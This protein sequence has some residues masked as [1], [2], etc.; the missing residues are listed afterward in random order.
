MP[1]EDSRLDES[2][3]CRG[4]NETLPA[5]DSLR[6]EARFTLY[7]R[8]G[9]VWLHDAMWVEC[10]LTMFWVTICH[11]INREM[12]WFVISGVE[13]GESA[14]NK[15]KSATHKAVMKKKII[16]ERHWQAL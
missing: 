4:L 1:N 9:A 2:E 5:S 13:A 16:P 8:A 6:M 3:R 12:K 15:T 14:P 7:G 11:A 10:G